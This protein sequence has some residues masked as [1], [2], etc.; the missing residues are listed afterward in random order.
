MGQGYSMTTLS[1]ASASID[2]PELADLVHEKTLASARFMKSVRAR[3]QQGFVFVKAVMKPYSSFQVQEYVRQIVEERNILA[4]IPNALGYQRIV[5]VGSGGFLVRQ[6]MFS[7]VYDRM[8]TRPFLEDIE[9]KW[10]AFQLLCA[11]RDCHARNVYHGDIKTENLLVTSWNWLYLTDFSSSF[12][13]THLPEDNPADFSFFFDTSSRRT[14]YIAPERFTTTNSGDRQGGLNWAMDIFSAGCAI[15]EIFLEGPIFS[16]SQLFKYRGGD[17]SPEHTHLNKIEDH[18]VRAMILNMIE[19]DPEK[20]YSAEQLLSFYKSKIFPEY[21]Y[22]FLHQYMLDLTRPATASKPVGLDMDSLGASDD[23]ID[24]VYHDFDKISFFLGYGPSPTKRSSRSPLALRSSNRVKSPDSDPALYDGSLLFLTLVVSSMRNTAKASARLKA[25][26]LLVAFA[27]RLPDEAKLDRILPY[28]AGLLADSSDVVKTAAIYAVTSIFEMIEVVSPIN[29][30]VFPEYIFP[31]LRQFVLG[32]SNEPS[33]LIRTA[34]AS[35]LASLALSASRILDMVHAIRTDGRLPALR[36]DEWA[37]ESSYHGLYD[38]ARAELVPYFEESTIALI[39]D[40]EPS[41]RRALL[42]SVSRLCVFFGSSKASDV[43][44]THLN[45]YLNDKDWILRCSFFEALVGV[46]SYVGTSS[47]E[48]FILPIMVG[49][50][51]DSESFV[52]EKVFRSLARMA[53]LG[54]LQKSTTWE[55]VSIAARFLVHPSIWV[56]ESAVQFIVLSAKYVSAADHYCIILPIIQPF[57]KNPISVLTEEWILDNLKRPLPKIVFDSA[58]HWASRK[59][60]SLFWTAASRDGALTLSDP[61]TPQNPSTLTRRLLT[62]IPPSQKDKDDQPSLEQLRNLGM[63][64][65]DEIKLLALREYMLKVSRHKPSEDADERNRMLNNIIT[66]NQIDVTP[67]NIFFDQRETI[68]ETKS[69]PT[70]TQQRRSRRDERHSLADALLDASTSIDD[71]AVRRKSPSDNDSGTA[72]PSTKPIEIQ[73]RITSST[74]ADDS[75]SINVERASGS[76]R[77]SVSYGGSSPPGVDKLSL[78]RNPTRGLRHRNSGLNLMNRTDSAKAD[79][80]IS[81]IS[82]NA[83][84]K[85]DGP[86]HRK[87]TAGPS[88]LTVTARMARSSWSGSPRSGSRTPLYELN[89]SYTGNDVHVLRLLDNHFLENFPVDQMDFGGNRPA[90]DVKAPIKRAT[91]VVQQRIGKAAQQEE[92]GFRAEPWR[93]SG[94]LVTQFSEHTAAIN[95]VCVAPD[96]AFF[97]TASDDGTCKIWD[98]IRLEKNVTPRSRYTHR[99]GNGAKVKSL[100]FVEG[101]HTFLS[102]AADGSIHAVRVD[103]KSVEGG[104]SS[105]YGKPSLVRDYQIPSNEVGNLDDGAVN[106]MPEYAVWLY[107]YRAPTSQSVLLA[108]TNKCRILAIDMKN[109]VI[110]HSMNNPLHHGTPTTFCVDK[111]RH[112][113]LLGTSRGILDLWDLRFKL[114]LRSFGIQTNSMIDRIHIHPTKGHGRWVMVSAGGEIS[115]W[116]VEKMSCREILRPSTFDPRSG[117]TRAY[118]AWFP[119]DENSEKVFSRFLKDVAEDD[120]LSEPALHSSPTEKSNGS[121]VPKKSLAPHP[122]SASNAPIPNLPMPAV[123]VL[124][125]YLLNSSQPDNPYKHALLFTGGDDRNLRYWDMQR[126]ENSFIISGPQLYGEDGVMVKPKYDVTHPLALSAGAQIALIQ[127]K[128]SDGGAGGTGNGRNHAK[129]SSRSSKD[130]TASPARSHTPTLVTPGST[131]AG[132]S[133]SSKPG[134]PTSLALKTSPGATSTAVATSKPPRNT[135]ISAAH[136]QVLRTHVDGITDV[137]V[138]RKPYGC[139]VSVDRGGTVFVFH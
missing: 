29:A 48:K 135:V 28:V 15:A 11:V 13:P 114:R 60:K 57:L 107:H 32:P 112:W 5:E 87:N 18:E 84:G 38:I 6:Y 101:T 106:L 134:T 139:V 50:L 102:G 113:L 36:E 127:E 88:A 105:R 133:T 39:T 10:L 61:T 51:T 2:V 117:T 44:L 67:Q 22:S 132:M 86:L 62:R 123:Y 89:H 1:A 94:Q 40:P 71:H 128:L 55:L 65:E 14:C 54:L 138:L 82:E 92:R 41:V 3:S 78:R 31:R 104:E 47:L 83:F 130:L 124:H 24:R 46:A 99:R 7:S 26:D 45:T 136:Q 64:A 27:E 9:K 19:L 93:P 42:G 25:C 125:D 12:K 131:A 53:A 126:P 68:R 90:A 108:A 70:M 17:Y 72:T 96:H 118:E 34:Y 66:L 122:S 63:A 137:V 98:T 80:E 73:R 77:P 20:R 79:A 49:S 35:C 76:S 119:D 69:R 115:V 43:I 85:V 74:E 33:I 111:K 58:V 110:I 100:C 103:Y 4:D 56:R 91:D 23:K 121:P 81:T 129:R 120:D 37:P 21:F 97:V 8:S 109:M 52:V 116:D 75:P 16:L 30:Y 59:G 95:R